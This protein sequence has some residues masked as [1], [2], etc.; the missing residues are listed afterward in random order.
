[1]TDAVKRK[2]MVVDDDPDLGRMIRARLVSAG[3]EA[4]VVPD[5]VF[6]AQEVRQFKP[7]LVVLDLMLPAGGGLE[8]LRRLKASIH[9]AHVPVLVLT[10]VEPDVY[11]G[12]VQQVREIG[13]EGFLR[14]P[15]DGQKF[16]A[17]VSRI[18]Q[19]CAPGDRG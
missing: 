5:A 18:L 16:L 19:G 12:M 13:V 17:E 1:M 2:V 9:T 11:E 4:L 14:K 7:D 15:F 10:G 8:V 6:A 3:F